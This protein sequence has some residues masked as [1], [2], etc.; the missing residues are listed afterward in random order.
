MRYIV[1]I[2]DVTGDRGQRAWKKEGMGSLQ[3]RFQ[4]FKKMLVQKLD[5]RGGFGFY[6][7]KYH[8]LD[9]MVKDI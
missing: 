4:H 8:P 6:T 9:N 3:R 2:A 5:E 7:L 1:I